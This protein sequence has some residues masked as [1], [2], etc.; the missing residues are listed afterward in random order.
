MNVIHDPDRASKARL[1]KHRFMNIYFKSIF[2]KFEFFILN[3]YFM[4][5][6]YFDVLI[7]KIIFFKKK[8][9]FDIFRNENEQLQH[10]QT[11]PKQ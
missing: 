9:Y 6:N 3:Y 7:S 11:P 5:L 2:K 8:Y 4:F 1:P 10:F